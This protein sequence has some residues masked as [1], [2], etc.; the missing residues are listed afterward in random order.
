LEH[1]IGSAEQIPEVNPPPVQSSS[2]TCGGKPRFGT[3]T[4]QRM[5]RTGWAEMLPKD[6]TAQQ[7][8]TPRADYE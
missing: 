3:S 4:G 6:R 2:W 1:P 5:E 8:M 7:A